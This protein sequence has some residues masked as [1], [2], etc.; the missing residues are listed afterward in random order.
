VWPSAETVAPSVRAVETFIY[1]GR[2][3]TKLSDI[4]AHGTVIQHQ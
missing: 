2:I 1:L 3:L 4:D